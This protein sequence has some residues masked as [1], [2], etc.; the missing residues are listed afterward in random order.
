MA[1]SV[2]RKLDLLKQFAVQWDHLYDLALKAKERTSVISDEEDARFKSMR[3][4]I[5]PIYTELKNTFG[6][7][8]DPSEHAV[9][10]LR[11]TSS[12]K[13][14]LDMPVADKNILFHRLQVVQANIQEMSE[15]ISPGAIPPRP[16]KAVTAGAIAAV[17][18]GPK[19]SVSPED[20]EESRR[21]SRPRS[22]G[23][24][25]SRLMMDP[26]DFFEYQ[27]REHG[28]NKPVKF[29]FLL[30]MLI[31]LIML[32]CSI[33][34]FRETIFMTDFA[35]M[36]RNAKN[37]FY[38]LLLYVAVWVAVYMV[39]TTVALFLLLLSAGWSQ[40]CMKIVGGKGRYDHN[41]GIH[42]YTYA[43][44]VFTPL[45]LVLP[46][47]VFIPIAYQFILRVLAAS[48]VHKI[49][50]ARS[51]VARLLVLVPYAAAA[52]ILSRLEYKDNWQAVT[53][54]NAFVSSEKDGILFATPIP[55]GAS[56]E[57]EKHLPDGLAY[58]RAK[59]PA[60]E[61][62]G[63]IPETALAYHDTGFFNF[64]RAEMSHLPVRISQFSSRLN[65][66]ILGDR[67]NT[68]NKGSPR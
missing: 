63:T 11:R 28:I 37:Q 6:K 55:R 15:A 26:V 4:R 1:A 45:Y 35:R 20:I 24:T 19:Y 48:K 31:G 41:Y 22:F 32:L 51:L 7:S 14:V 9:N 50:Y 18:E 10:V 8:I 44:H 49:S 34:I 53:G 3:A 30:F 52:I 57:V 46:V 65:I 56:I 33:F 2:N 5:L 67:R 29:I 60:G 66:R 36:L 62:E 59:T 68:G 39:I 58:I 17:E 54:A 12:L 43:P 61:L 16:E 13:Q 38:E 42:C 21:W 47:L 25:W 64:L 27:D 40:V 23:Q